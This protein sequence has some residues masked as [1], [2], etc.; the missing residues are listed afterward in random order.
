M[1]YSHLILLNSKKKFTK[2]SFF[3][4]RWCLPFDKENKRTLKNCL[5][6]HWNDEKKKEA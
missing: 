2:N 4:G 3:L 5:N 6:Y 1:K